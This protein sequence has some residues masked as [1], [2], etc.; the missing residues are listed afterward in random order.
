MKTELSILTIVSLL[1]SQAAFGLSVIK[2]QDAEGAIAYAEAMCPPGHTQVTK[3]KYNEYRAA[4][5][6]SHKSL[7]KGAEFP[8]QEQPLPRTSIKLFQSRLTQA[9]G[10]VSA[11]KTSMKEYYLTQ[12]KWP[13]TLKDLGFAARDM[14]TDFITKTEVTPKGQISITLDDVF[15]ENKEVW[16]YPKLEMGGTQ[17]KWVCYA[18][19]P[20]SLLHDKISDQQLCL[21]RYF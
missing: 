1:V 12:G 19:F 16:F 2:C 4:K 11:V 6:V 13:G 7:E 10:S 15:G 14:T 20:N 5:S 8:E 9:L 18:N 3:I 21:S 17:M